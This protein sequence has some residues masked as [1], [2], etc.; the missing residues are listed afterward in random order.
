MSELRSKS[1]I[2][3]KSYQ[4]HAASHAIYTLN[5]KP[6]IINAPLKLVKRM[7]MKNYTEDLHVE[8]NADEEYEEE[9]Q[10]MVQIDSML[11]NKR[12]QDSPLP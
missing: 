2:K 10:Q 8:E 5:K 12:Y 1:Q 11:M 6:N 7:M 9:N 3:E 4:V